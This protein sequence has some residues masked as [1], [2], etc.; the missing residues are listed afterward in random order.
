MT[1]KAMTADVLQFADNLHLYL[2]RFTN[3]ALRIRRAG[4]AAAFSGMEAV[5]KRPSRIQLLTCLCAGVALV[6]GFVFA[7][8]P[9]CGFTDAVRTTAPSQDV[10][11]FAWS[12]D[13]RRAAVT[14]K[15]NS[16]E[17]SDIQTRVETFVRHRYSHGVPYLRAKEL[18][19]E[20][21]PILEAMLRDTSETEYWDTIVMTMGFIGDSSSVGTLVDFL[22]NRFDGEVT[23]RQFG[24]LLSVNNALGN[25][26]G[27]GSLHALDYL[28]TACYVK[29][30]LAKG[31]KWH[32]RHYSGERLAV[33]LA[34]LGANGLSIS[35]TN[36][37]RE[38][39]LSLQKHPES[40]R[41]ASALRPNIEEGLERIDRIQK[42]GALKV[43][44][45]Q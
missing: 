42:E 27:N 2:A 17:A 39:L 5:M 36:R 24:A 9:T 25:I 8:M 31:L 11:H 15:A 41:S 16:E 19:A 18:G 32:Y 3:F 30:W 33:L 14:V 21:L 4:I 43:F 10:V 13:S 35:G 1:S 37:A 29:I 40:A 22:E 23:L 7:L 26:A 45:R 12:P 38:I 34:K 6:P 44:G 28:S 20:A